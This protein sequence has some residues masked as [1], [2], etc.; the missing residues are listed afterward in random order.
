MAVNIPKT[1]AVAQSLDTVSSKSKS[2]SRSKS[3]VTMV[4]SVHKKQQ[5]TDFLV[6]A[7]SNSDSEIGGSIAPFTKSVITDKL[8][9]T[10]CLMMLK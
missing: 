9:H 1:K 8:G 2:Q 5:I 6:K 10:E 4:K 3:Q 7:R